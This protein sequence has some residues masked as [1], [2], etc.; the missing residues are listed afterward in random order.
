MFHSKSSQARPSIH[1]SNTFSLSEEAFLLRSLRE[2]V[3]VWAN[4][5]GHATFNLNINNGSADLKLGFQLGQP[6][7]PHL[8]PQQQPFFCPMAP[9]N[10]RRKSPSQRRRDRLRAARHQAAAQHHAAAPQP[11][12]PHHQAAGSAAG[13]SCQ[14]A[15]KAPALL[16]PFSGNL[17]P[18]KPRKEVNVSAPETTPPIIEPRRE[19]AA[20]SAPEATPSCSPPLPPSTP[21]KPT[22]P[23]PQNF[24]SRSCMDVSAT[25]KQLFVDHPPNVKQAVPVPL[26]LPEQVACPAATPASGPCPPPPAPHTRVTPAPR[27]TY[28]TR[29]DQLWTRLFTIV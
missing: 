6:S 3:N 29:E 11:G 9:L 16:L 12:Q 13:D 14:K 21:K 25:K 2:V 1:S 28:Q 4:G 17:L 15:T 20:A 27:M 10:I 26:A 22:S 5:S 7:E 19:P 8:H 23:P 24:W 18:I